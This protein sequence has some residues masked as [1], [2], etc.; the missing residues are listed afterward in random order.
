MQCKYKIHRVCLCCMSVY[1]IIVVL[2]AL[3]CYDR[4]LFEARHCENEADRW[5]ANA[6]SPL[7]NIAVVTVADDYIGSDTVLA[8]VD[9]K[10][11][12]AAVRGYSFITPT[13][14]ERQQLTGGSDPKRAKF[15]LISKVIEKYDAVLWVDIDAVVMRYDIDMNFLLQEMIINDKYLAI[16]PDASVDDMLNSGVLL[17]RNGGPMKLFLQA[18]AKAHTMI[19]LC[20]SLVICPPGL[21]DQSI[22]AFLTGEWPTCAWYFKLWPFAPVHPNHKH[23]KK[24]IHEVPACIFNAV[25]EEATSRSFIQHCYGGGVVDK[26]SPMSRRNNKGKG[27]CVNFLLDQSMADLEKNDEYYSHTR[28]IDT[29]TI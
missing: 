19:M 7:Y 5:V 1:L 6:T 26:L 17:I 9:N 10:K 4:R 23:F 21:Y 8:A 15:A 25:P 2:L 22:I 14:S 11:Q 13:A 18:F 27:K 16:A 29:T 12:Y 20:K 3:Y 28:T 24:L